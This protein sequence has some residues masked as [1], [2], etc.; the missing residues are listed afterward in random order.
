MRVNKT[1]S[2]L[3]A[4]CAVVV[5]SAVSGLAA[6]TPQ[7]HQHA[8]AAKAKPPEAKCQAMMAEKE[9]MMADMKVADQ[10]LD[11]LVATMNTASGMDKMA[12]TATV[13]SEMVTQRRTMRDGMMKMQEDMMGHMMEHMQAGAASMAMCPMM[14]Q[15][16]GKKP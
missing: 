11:D 13:V 2:A 15:M 10:R 8:A 14:K 3:V 1:V 16:G 5:M 9:K 12:A 4:G 7:E 6:Q